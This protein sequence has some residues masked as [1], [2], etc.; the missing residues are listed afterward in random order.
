MQVKTL[1]T[2]KTLKLIVTTLTVGAVGLA[3][4]AITE[5]VE[6]KPGSKSGQP[7]LRI[8]FLTG[9]SSEQWKSTGNNAPYNRIGQFELF[10]RDHNLIGM[11]KTELIELLGEPDVATSEK[12]TMIY[13]LRAVGCINANVNLR[14]GLDKETVQRWRYSY[15]TQK[16]KTWVTR[17]VYLLFEDL[18]LPKP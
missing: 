4:V 8:P 12:D 5:P 17:N 15:A 7:A 14:I 3:L 10:L 2:S 9:F 6:Q 18:K 13:S 16:D 1:S 11:P